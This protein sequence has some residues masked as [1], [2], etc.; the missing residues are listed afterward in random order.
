MLYLQCFMWFKRS[1]AVIL[2][3]YREKK[4]IYKVIKDFESNNFIDE[5]VVVN[6][7]AEE[8]TIDEVKKTKAKIVYENKQGYGFAIQT[9]I[10]NT[11]AD[12][13]IIS[14]PDGSFD[15]NDVIKL[16]S[17]SQDFDTVFGS[18]THLPL[19]QKGSD[20]SLLKRFGDVL[21]GKLVTLLFLCY[22]LT[23][24]GCT[25]RLTNRRGWNKIKQECKSGGAI[26]AT[27]W[28][29]V[30]AKN[31][32]KFIEIPINYKARVGKS[33]LSDTFIKRFSWGMKKFYYIW[34]VWIFK[35]LNKKMYE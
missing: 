35:I 32:I 20:M 10:N 4:S 28:V 22:P 14:E 21:L 6:N 2:P 1:V 9:G 23:D 15:G 13:L 30:A 8:G 24:L 26:L 34:K 29:L 33:T 19:I 16:L 12:I 27:E 3:T 18:R 31:K 11:N 17:Y 7:N 25:L 5:I